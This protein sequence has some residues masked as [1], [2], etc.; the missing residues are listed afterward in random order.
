MHHFISMNTPKDED[1]AQLNRELIGP[2]RVDRPTVVDEKTGIVPPSW[3]KGDEYASKSGI[4]AMMTLK[5]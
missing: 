3:W 2:P 4:A 5:R 1:R